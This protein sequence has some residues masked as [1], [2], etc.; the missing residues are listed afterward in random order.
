M[1]LVRQS[2]RGGDLCR[3]HTVGEERFGAPE[4][5]GHQHLVRRNVKMGFEL[6]LEMVRAERYDAGQLV[7]RQ[8]VH[9]VVVQVLAHAF[10]AVRAFLNHRRV[11]GQRPEGLNQIQQ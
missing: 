8:G 11:M 9:V 1:R 6:A 10:E 4:A 3:R 2:G 5:N 7:Q